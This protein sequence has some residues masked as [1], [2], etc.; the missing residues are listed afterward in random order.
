MENAS[1]TGLG[2]EAESNALGDV[3]KHERQRDWIAAL[4]V[5]VL[6]NILR[7]A[8]LAMFAKA[9]DDNLWGLLNKWDAVYYTEIA[10]A[11]YFNA[12]IATEGNV[13]ETTMA[14]FPGFPLLIKLVSFLGF[15]EPIAAILLNFVFTVVMAAGVMAIAQRMGADFKARVAAAIAVTSAPMSIVFAMPY[16]EALFGALTMWA[17]V[18]LIDRKWLLAG[19]LVFALSAVR[20]TS[21]DVIL[22]F[23]VIVLLWG[24]REWKAWVALVA[25]A[26]PLLGYLTMANHYL[27]AAGGYFG[28]QKEHWN[29]QFDFGVATFKWVKSTLMT[30]D[31][32]GFLLSTSVI[33]GAPILLVLA[34]RKLPLPVWLF[35][36]ALIAN[37]LLSDGIMH[38]R[39]RL[40]LPA[41]VLF[42]PWTIEM[43]KWESSRQMAF[44]MGAVVLGGAWFSA[45]MLA[46][47]DWA[48]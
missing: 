37:V 19:L 4:G 22:V 42:I 2:E 8:V 29:S 17:L 7:I 28:I 27:A 40:L 10:R 21:A 3:V 39:P 34:W 11:G 32:A 18:A 5:G 24:A 14:F 44:V 33:V 25:S 1:K 30:A 45:H 23:G 35:S 9:N 38:S 48:I 20:L 16:T 15:S 13:Y 46:V 6:G 31:H 26:L 41:A 43:S 36:A 47:F 12:D